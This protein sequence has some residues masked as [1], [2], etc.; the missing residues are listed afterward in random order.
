MLLFSPC[1]GQSS[2][3][4]VN[5]ASVT[6]EEELF[7][8]LLWKIK[9][10]LLWGFSFQV[11][12]PRGRDKRLHWRAPIPSLSVQPLGSA[13]WAWLVKRLYKLCM[14]LCNSYIQMHRDLES[15]LEEA[16]LLRGGTGGGGGDHV[17]FLP[18]F[19]S[20]TSTPT[21]AGGLSARGTPSEEGGYR[22]HTDMSAA[23]P[24]D[25]P[26]PSPGF[27]S[28]LSFLKSL[29]Q[30]SETFFSHVHIITWLYS[31]KLVMQGSSVWTF[32]GYC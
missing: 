32:S 21:S 22:S 12:P 23:S 28:D 31:R 16:A 3:V 15:T 10:T 29:K 26:T 27:R 4:F 19:Q 30:I 11:S 7:K 6:E 18:L 17:F 5:F 14:D 20:E 24:G 1:W 9:S 2:G 8:V 13:D 25:T